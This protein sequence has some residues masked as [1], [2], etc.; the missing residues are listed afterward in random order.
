MYYWRVFP[1]WGKLNGPW[2][3]MQ[4]F[5]IIGNPYLDSNWDIFDV[6]AL[7]IG[8]MFITGALGSLGYAVKHKSK[9]K[10]KIGEKMQKFHQKP[11][12]SKSNL[13]NQQK[14]SESERLKII[15]REI[16]NGLPPPVPE[17][18][19]TGQKAL[20]YAINGLNL[21]EEGQNL[22]ALYYMHGALKMGVREPE[23][24]HL[25]RIVFDLAFKNN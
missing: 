15:V 10:N 1:V 5:Q 22:K 23:N 19:P 13:I 16:Q 2:S 25:K 21:L 20:T 3:N 18:S 24:S 11:I 4:S 17:D 14:V 7:L 9:K 8:F 12:T 6:L